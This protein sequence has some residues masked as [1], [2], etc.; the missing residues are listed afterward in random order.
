MLCAPSYLWTLAVKMAAA[1]V[2]FFEYNEVAR[3]G[4]Y[5]RGYSFR[6]RVGV[7]GMFLETLTLFQTK[8]CYFPYIFSDLNQSYVP[9]FK[10]RMITKKMRLIK[11]KK[12]AQILAPV[13]EIVQNLSRFQIKMVKIYVQLKTK[14][15]KTV[16]F[17]SAH[18]YIVLDYEQSLFPSLVRC[19]SKKKSRLEE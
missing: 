8:I 5:S 13:A 15:V 3:T 2:L 7:C 4:V 6:F 12:H 17:N 10:R 11:T 1:K 18:T 9:Y 16:S 14:R 19:A